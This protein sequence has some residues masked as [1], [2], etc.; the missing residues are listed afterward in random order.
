MP[1]DYAAFAEARSHFA[2]RA[3]HPSFDCS[4]RHAAGGGDFG[5]VASLDVKRHERATVFFAEN[6]ERG[7]H[8]FNRLAGRRSV[9]LR[10]DQP[11]GI[12]R[13]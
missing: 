13:R 8:F 11:G 4:H 6:V 12:E 9:G 5:I 7:G 10:I 2:A 3:M 1:F